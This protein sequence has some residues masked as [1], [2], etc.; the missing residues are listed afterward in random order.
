VSF[1]VRDPLEFDVE[2][3]LAPGETPSLR[4]AARPDDASRLGLDSWLTVNADRETRVIVPVPSVTSSAA[5]G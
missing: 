3:I 2:L 5:G 1:Y 4:L